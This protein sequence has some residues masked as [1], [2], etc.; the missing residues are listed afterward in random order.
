MLRLVSVV[1]RRKTCKSTFAMSAPTPTVFFDLELGADRVEDRYIPDKAG[2]K[3]VCL[4]KKQPMK[5]RPQGTEVDAKYWTDFQKA[6]NE[7]LEDSTVKSIVLDPFTVV[8]QAAQASFLYDLKRKDPNVTS[9]YPTTLYATPNAWMRDIL[10]Q[11]KL[12]DKNLVLVHHTKEGY[13]KGEPT[14]EEV[15][16]GFKYTA[17]M[18]DV[19]LWMTKKD[20]KPIGTITL[21]GLS[22]SAEG[23]VREQPTWGDIEGWIDKL[24]AMK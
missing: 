6:Y 16:D 17:D 7:A 9:I 4:V 2:I 18:V 3:Y 1:G 13:S 15:P 14:G 19:E 21:C 20:G 22:T 12:H 5:A 10:L 11:A 24:R 23:S 8:W